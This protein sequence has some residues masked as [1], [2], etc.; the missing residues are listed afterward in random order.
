MVK[1]TRDYQLKMKAEIY[2]AWR[3]GKRNVLAVAPTGSG[4]THLK[5]SI[6]SECK[7]PGVAIA[8]RQ[9][10]TGQISEAVAEAGVYHRLICSEPVLKFIVQ[11]QIKK[12][13]QSFIHHQSPMAV[14]GVDTLN[15]RADKLVQW[16]NQVKI[17]DID[18]AHHVLDGNKW[19]KAAKLFPNAFGLGVTATPIRCD[20]K[21]LGRAKSGLFDHMVIGP[22]MREL[23]NR[24]YLADYVIFG[25]PPSI[26]RSKIDVSENTGEFVPDSVK[27]AAHKS[28]ITGDIV[29]HYLKLAA[30][31]QGITFTVDVDLAVDTAKAFEQRGV[32]AA[33]IS[34]RT[35][36]NVRVQLIEKYRRGELKQLVNVDLFGEGMD[37]PA[38]EV[39]SMGRPTQSYGLYV[40][41]F[42]RCIR[43]SPG[44]TFGIVIDH[45]GNVIQHKL[46]DRARE[47]SLDDEE[48]GKRAKKLD[49]EI[50]VT[51]CVACFRAFEAV[52]KRCPFCGH[53][54]EPAS[55]GAPEHVAG[56]LNEYGPELLASLGREISAIDGHPRIPL[57]V[58]GS[59]AVAIR[60]SW[61]ERQEAQRALRDCIALWAGIQREVYD[62]SDS[63]AYRRFYFMF[64]IDVMSAQKLGRPDAEKLATLIR[65]T[66]I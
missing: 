66:F 64:G 40:Q 15:L 29:D 12:F 50:P 38:V 27:K 13:G 7:V 33:A 46:P 24:G 19:G 49:D 22:S 21:S 63:E 57:N 36:A 10:L 37:V 53:V 4:K 30:G 20:R 14:A 56:D 23:I 42:G 34:D 16:C 59:A 54:Q 3:A 9:E 62:R 25:P 45:V 1:E 5:A 32:P 41:Q 61:Q 11:Q 39:V 48:R 31:K 47:W 26:D 60:R 2:E 44:K 17:W 51:T 55:R 52:T 8:H 35:P 65:S 18:E 6:F 58:S 28:R 43:I